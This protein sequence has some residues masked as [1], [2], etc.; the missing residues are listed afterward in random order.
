MDTEEAKLKALDTVVEWTK[1]LITISA[2][3]LIFSTTFLREVVPT[4][5]AIHAQPLLLLSWFF[6]LLSIFCGILVMGAIAGSLDRTKDVSTL[7]TGKSQI[8]GTGRFQLGLFFFGILL[9]MGFVLCNM[10]EES[11]SSVKETSE[12]C[13]SSS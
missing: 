1:Q 11:S 13:S 7:T 10:P 2:A 12:Q 6:L 9:F 3:L 8:K 5:G 4:P